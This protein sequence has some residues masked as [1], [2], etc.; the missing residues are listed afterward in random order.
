MGNDHYEWNDRL[1]YFD[2]RIC[3][4]KSFIW[5]SCSNI[6]HCNRGYRGGLSYEKMFRWTVNTLAFTILILVVLD[7]LQ[8]CDINHSYIRELIYRYGI[9]FIG[10]SEN[11]AFYY[12]VF[13]R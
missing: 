8:I 13:L 7:I 10:K 6:A 9:G 2:R 3:Q 5:L 1:L 12:K 11:Y 4:R